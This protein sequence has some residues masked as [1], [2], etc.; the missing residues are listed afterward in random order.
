MVKEVFISNKS[1]FWC[2]ILFLLVNLFLSFLNRDDR[3][4]W[5]F[6]WPI[7]Q[8]SNTCVNLSAYR[9]LW[10][11]KVRPGWARIAEAFRIGENPCIR[12]NSGRLWRALQSL[13]CGSI[14]FAVARRVRCS[15]YSWNWH[16]KTDKDPSR[17]RLHA[18]Q[19][20]NYLF[21]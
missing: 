10:C 12:S 6:D 8:K 16:T 11:S 20:I 17:E 13:E 15:R 19:S 4:R 9:K 3:I 18:C 1:L 21:N 2:E 7:V 14:A 5:E